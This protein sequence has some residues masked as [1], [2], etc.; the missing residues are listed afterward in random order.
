MSFF[1]DSISTAGSRKRTLSSPDD[2]DSRKLRRTT[3][4]VSSS[5]SINYSIGDQSSH[6]STLNLRNI[7]RLSNSSFTSTSLSRSRSWTNRSSPS[8][9]FEPEFLPP[10]RHIR[11]RSASSDLIELHDRLVAAAAEP[12]PP[13]PP[14]LIFPPESS[15]HRLRYCNTTVDSW[16][17]DG[18]KSTESSPAAW[19][20]DGVL[21]FGRGNRVHYKNM[22][23][24]QEVGQL[25]KIGDNLGELSHVACGPQP[26]AHVAAAT[27]KGY[28]QIWDVAAKKMLSSW[29]ASGG[30]SSLQWN[31]PVLTIGGLRGSLKNH[32]TRMQEPA[33]R[34]KGTR[35]NKQRNKHQTRVSCL[36]WHDNGHFLAS[37]DADGIVYCWDQRKP[38]AALDIGEPGP[39]QKSIKHAGVIRGLAWT[40]GRVL[41]T[42]DAAE[43]GT[44]TIRLWDVSRTDEK[45]NS[46][47]CKIELNAQVTSLRCS[48]DCAELLSTHGRAVVPP[49]D[50]NLPS[51][52]RARPG[53]ANS[54]MVHTTGTLRHVRTD[55]IASHPVEGSV[56]RPDG[57]KMMFVV[58][59]AKQLPMW[60]IWGL[61][62]RRAVFTPP[63]I[64]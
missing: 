31:G 26:R 29:K 30:V 7:S 5:L 3:S 23:L 17:G 20:G 39:G 1:G 56:M 10:D 45:Y 64:R 41:A 12:P 50:P 11:H 32:D 15:K 61:P 9:S 28:V 42:G 49:E 13:P 36:S 43:D 21:I 57:R 2:A 16:L 62:P 47:K 4:A 27:D 44:G 55:V 59:E 34:K 63:S 25:C 38:G 33:E 35:L 54:V 14:P 60:E 22:T 58:P 48:V 6:A 52:S 24:R 53:V 8:G 46:A 37:G 18:V 40:P 19:S 51:S